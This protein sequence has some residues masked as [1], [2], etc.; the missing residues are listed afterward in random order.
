MTSVIA[1]AIIAIELG[2]REAAAQ[3]LPVIEPH[4][5]E[6]S[7]N[8]VTSQGPVGAYVGKLASL[9]G[10]H[11]EADSHLR[12]ALATA[13][14]F[15]WTYHRATTL[16]ALA[17]AQHRQLGGL[18]EEGRLWLSEASELCRAYGYQSWISQIDDLMAGQPA[19]AFLS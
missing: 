12:A 18:D 10:R 6:I 13:T 15:G 1:Y 11:E 7:F 9:L 5:A 14:A 19:T 3:L 4:A 2:D 8:G 16:F 17:Q